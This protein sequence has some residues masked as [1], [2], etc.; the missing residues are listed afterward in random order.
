M[1]CC[2]AQNPRHAADPQIFVL[3]LV[4]PDDH[5]AS[6]GQAQMSAYRQKLRLPTSQRLGSLVS[7]KIT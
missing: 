1:V 3:P 2:C 4:T 6:R 5:L 7:Q